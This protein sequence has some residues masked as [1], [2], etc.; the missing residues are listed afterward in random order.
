LSLGE[1]LCGLRGKVL[2]Q[3]SQ[4]VHEEHNDQ[5]LFF[6]FTA[7]GLLRLP[8]PGGGIG[9]LFPLQ[10]VTPYQRAQYATQQRCQDKQ[11]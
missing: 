8:I 3:G 5:I 11:P 1:I 2:P 6:V 7:S 9:I 10:Q 4:R